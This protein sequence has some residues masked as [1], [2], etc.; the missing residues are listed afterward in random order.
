MKSWKT[1]NIEVIIDS[2]IKGTSAK[3]NEVS[4]IS[5]LMNSG[6]G[7]SSGLF[8]RLPGFQIEKPLMN[9]L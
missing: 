4:L 2:E 9:Y 7:I 3:S 5:E 6:M 1:P 8:V